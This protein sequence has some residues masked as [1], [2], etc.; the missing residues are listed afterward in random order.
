MKVF[1]IGITGKRLM[2][3]SPRKARILVKEGRAYVYCKM[4][5]TIRLLY[6]S[7]ST[8]QQLYRGVD[9]GSQHIGISVVS[10]NSENKAKVLYKAQISL[11]STMEKRSLLETRRDYRRGRRHRKTRYRKPKF[12]KNTIRRYNVKPDKKGRHWKKAAYSHGTDREKGW[13]TPSMQSKADH[14]IRWIHRFDDV[15]PSDTLGII[16]VGRFDIARMKDPHVHNELYQMGPMYDFENIKAYVFDRDGY[17]C[18]VCG[19]KGGSIRKDKSTVKLKAHHIDFKSKGSTDNPDRMATVCDKCHTA[20]AHKEGGILYEW[21]IKEKCFSRGYRDA[22][23]MNI[24][25]KRLWKAFP[26]NRFTYGNITKADRKR[27]HLEKSHANDATAIA[28]LGCNVTEVADHADVVYIQQQRKKKRSLHE[29]NPRKGRKTPNRESKRNKKNTKSVTVKGRTYCLWDK[30]SLG[31]K[32]GWISGFTGSMAYVRDE[33]NEFI[34][35]SDK[36]RS[37]SLSVLKVLGHNNNWI[38]GPLMQLG[39]K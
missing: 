17:K 4:P 5:Y 27:L 11:R 14:H 16:E 26:L 39:K 35:V 19:T 3:T 10:V 6:K 32:K 12:R 7:G 2:P 33:N 30:V 38:T 1:V 18:R 21:M 31:E 9:T 37:V 15:L 29:A 24:I 28:L 8:T 20:A 23:V 13:L 22:T 25:R 34:T 36:Y